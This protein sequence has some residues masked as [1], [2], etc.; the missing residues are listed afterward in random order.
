MSASSAAVL[1]AV[2]RAPLI[3]VYAAT[4][5]ATGG[6]TD[7]AADVAGQVAAAAAVLDACVA[8]GLRLF[9]FTDR[10]PHA[11]EVFAALRRHRDRRHPGVL[12]GAG[13]IR[14]LRAAAAYRERGA[15]FLVAPFLD[16]EVARW[17]RVRDLF[18]APGAATPGE[19][20]RAV[21]C[22][23]AV[24]KLFPAGPLGPE[25]LRL[26]RGPDPDT[27]IMPSGGVAADE[28]SVRA[29][30]EAGASCLALGSSLIAADAHTPAGAEALSDRCRRLLR[31]F[32]DARP[33]AR[34]TPEGA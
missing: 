32:V 5:D 16:E 33:P 13:T 28:A 19:I 11:A 17:C 3:P 12:L 14:D 6:A 29:W 27:R 22:G 24:V 2:E 26:L 10:T 18:Y 8:G 31:A 25:F 21:R 23:A 7:G 9:E 34:P 20:R 4:P 15:D 1:A 30:A